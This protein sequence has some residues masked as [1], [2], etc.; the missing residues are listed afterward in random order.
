METPG[1]RNDLCQERDVR[2][3][4]VNDSRSSLASLEMHSS[5]IQFIRV[6]QIIINIKKCRFD[7]SSLVLGPEVEYL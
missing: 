4:C 7:S 6:I 3:A 2:T 1:R 5:F